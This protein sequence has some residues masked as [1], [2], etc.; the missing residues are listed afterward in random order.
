MYEQLD[1]KASYLGIPIRSKDDMPKP[2]VT[3]SLDEDWENAISDRWWYH[4]NKPNKP[5]MGIDI[6]MYQL[7]DKLLS[8]GG[9]E[10]C[11]P[12]FDGDVETILSRGQLWYGDRTIMKIGQPSRCHS[13]SAI[14]WKKHPENTILCTGYALSNDGMWR[15]HSWLVKIDEKENK[16]IETTTERVAYFGIAMP[17]MIAQEFYQQNK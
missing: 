15:C 1:K 5:P 14:L 4:K 2:I 17:E 13:N 11:M 16:I 6:K 8:M 10:V 7:R 12:T 9:Y 3:N